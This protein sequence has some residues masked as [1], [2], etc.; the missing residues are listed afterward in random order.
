MEIEGETG[1]EAGAEEAGEGQDAEQG[2]VAE[3]GSSGGREGF[4]LGKGLEEQ[5]GGGRFSRR[6]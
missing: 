3:V 4:G 2:E 5:R 6:G 1:E